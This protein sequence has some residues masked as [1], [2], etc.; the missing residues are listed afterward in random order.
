MVVGLC[1]YKDI[2]GV[3]NQGFHSARFMG[4][5]RNDIL[6]TF[7]IAFIIALL[8]YRKTLLKSFLIIS[9]LLFII[10]IFLHRLFCVN[11]TLNKMIF[12]KV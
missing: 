5:A 4:Y 9:I 7:G 11:T 1:Q 6:G 12:G 2:L 10:A 8:F 3:P